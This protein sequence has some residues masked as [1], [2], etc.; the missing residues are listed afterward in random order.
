MIGAPGKRRAK[1]GVYLTFNFF[2]VPV[3]PLGYAPTVLSRLANPSR[4][5]GD[6]RNPAEAQEA[7][8]A[9]E[10]EEEEE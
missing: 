10:E 4:A 5:G 7:A 1:I 8:A 6:K 3:C 9:A 2:Y